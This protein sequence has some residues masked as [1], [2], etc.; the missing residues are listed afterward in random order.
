M[1]HFLFTIF[2]CTSYLCPVSW[3]PCPY[4]LYHMEDV[5]PGLHWANTGLHEKN[6]QPAVCRRSQGSCS[7][8]LDSRSQVWMTGSNNILPVLMVQSNLLSS[9]FSCLGCCKNKTKLHFKLLQNVSTV[10]EHIWDVQ[11][12]D[13]FKYKRV[14]SIY[15][16]SFSALALQGAT[17][18]KVTVQGAASTREM[19]TCPAQDTQQSKAWA[20]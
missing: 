12:S 8:T 10:I 1:T 2:L 16:S 4:I 15:C 9:F 13:I 5:D 3:P 17:A 18:N 7:V 20:I 14:A 6:R 19:A 11:S